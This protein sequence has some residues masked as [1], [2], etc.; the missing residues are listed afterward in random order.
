MKIICQVQN[1]NVQF[2]LIRLGYTYLTAVEKDQF[3]TKKKKRGKE[4]TC[5]FKENKESFAK[6]FIIITQL[7]YQG[8]LKIRKVRKNIK[9]NSYYD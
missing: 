2:Q 7:S 5:W 6:D 8:K 1:G 3:T 9:T 4:L